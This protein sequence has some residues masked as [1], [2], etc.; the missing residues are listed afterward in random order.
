MKTADALVLIAEALDRNTKVMEDLSK[1]TPA[2]EG[3]RKVLD[4]YPRRTAEALIQGRKAAED[5]RQAVREMLIA[6][7]GRGRAR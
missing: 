4:E 5:S 6:Q 1:L 2:I 7:E 3:F